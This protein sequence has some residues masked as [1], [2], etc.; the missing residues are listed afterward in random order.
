MADPVD[1][2]RE[3]FLSEV[4]E[5]VESLSRNLLALDETL[6]AGKAEPGLINEAFRAMKACSRPASCLPRTWRAAST[7]R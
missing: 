2:A 6:K 1:K 4:Q 3:E 5:I 7:C